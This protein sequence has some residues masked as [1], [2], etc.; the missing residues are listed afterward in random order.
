MD[1][2]KGAS[3]QAL[4][5]LHTCYCGRLLRSCARA[6]LAQS[7][8][9]Q[10]PAVLTQEVVIGIG[11]IRLLVGDFNQDPGALVQQ[12]IWERYGWCNAQ[13]LRA[14]L[15]NHEW[16]PTC[17]GMTERDQIWLSLEAAQLMRAMSLHEQFADHS[18]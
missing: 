10:Q 15:L 17:K 1:H 3:H 2:W 14:Q 16:T 18:I 8:T 13:T 6:N 11:G 4:D 12:K 9:T 5:Q 7:E